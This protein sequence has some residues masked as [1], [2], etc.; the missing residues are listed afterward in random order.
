MAP[1]T[2][3]AVADSQCLTTARLYYPSLCAAAKWN[4][5]MKQTEITS[6]KSL[7]FSWY[8]DLQPTEKTSPRRIIVLACDPLQ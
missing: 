6:K 8:Y 4:G 5:Q 7:S 2:V 3:P 1:K